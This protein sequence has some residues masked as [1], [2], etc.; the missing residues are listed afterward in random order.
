[1]STPIE[2]AR[3]ILAEQ[4][5]SRQLRIRLTA[6]GDGSA[7]LEAPLTADL[8]QQH[9]FAHGGVVSALADGGMSFAAGSV[10]GTSVLTAEYKIN[11]LR[12]AQGDRLVARGR[13]IS[14]S[15]RQAV[16][17]CEVWS[18]SEAGETLCAVAMGTVVIPHPG[19]AQTRRD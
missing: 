1:M 13:V 17:T 10:L 6:F 7:E 4:P 2:V 19:A 3:N 11:F 8:E 16:C 12:P 14:H 9:G 15:Q 5:F 18:L